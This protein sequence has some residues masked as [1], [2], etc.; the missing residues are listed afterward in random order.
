MK[1]LTL[2]NTRGWVVVLEVSD[3]YLEASN[4]PVFLSTVG[5]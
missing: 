4:D 3:D 5:S 1:L 2:L